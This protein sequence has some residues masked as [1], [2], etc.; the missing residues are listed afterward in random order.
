MK[1]FLIKISYTVLPVWLII[2]GCVVY[3]TLYASP[4]ASG[5]IG[6][7]ACI[8]FGHS[9]NKMLKKE[10][11]KDTLFTILTKVEDLD[12][13]NVDVLTIGDS[14]SQQTNGGYQNYLCLNGLTVANC[15]RDLFANPFQFA[16]NVLDDNL[17]DSTKTKVLIVE[18][19]ERYFELFMNSF[20]KG[21]KDFP[22]KASSVKVQS[23][24]SVSRARD[25]ILIHLGIRPV[26]YTAKL[27]GDYFRSDNPDK[28]YFTHEDIEN[29]LCIKK[30]DETQVRYVY[31]SLNEKASQKGIRLMLLVAVDK[32]DLYQNHIVNNPYPKKTVIEDIGRIIGDTPN[33][34]L[35]KQYLLPLIEQHEKDVFM[36]N[37]THWSYKATKVVAEEIGRR[38]TNKPTT[39]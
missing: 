11:I 17:I 29:G 4:R 8:P 39:H 32:Y 23:Q 34:M 38:I 27:D 37:D 35:T 33:L 26:A 18:C 12:T 25:F 9:Y 10:M 6:R 31:N 19:G 22:N 28:L 16:Y 5:D 36:Y 2:V 21:K 20:K 13:V 3:I 14:F 7:A 24:W 30:E 15:D 1:K